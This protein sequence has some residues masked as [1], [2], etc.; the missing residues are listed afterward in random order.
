[1][2]ES[3]GRPGPK[4]PKGT[5]SGNPATRREAMGRSEP[6]KQKI[7]NPDWFVPVMSGLMIVGVLWVATF[8][9][10]AGSLPID[11]IGYWNLGIGM[12]LIMVGFAMST[13]WK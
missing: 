8:Y 11:A 10:S 6:K 4:K 9:I 7:G 1:M 12:G 3:K 13:R 2:P 5:S